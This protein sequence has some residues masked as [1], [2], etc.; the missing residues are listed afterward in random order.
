M[1]FDPEIGSYGAIG[2]ERA[3]LNRT[4]SNNAGISFPAADE[5]KIYDNLQMPGVFINYDGLDEGLSF[6]STNEP[7]IDTKLRMDNNIDLASNY[8][9]G[10]GTNVGL[11]FAG[12]ANATF[13]GNVDCG[14]LV[15]SGYV[16]TGVALLI[17]DPTPGAVPTAS[18]YGTLFIESAS[19]DLKF[20]FNSGTIKTIATDP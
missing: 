13:S 9:S 20:R 12:G 6:N 8:I 10:N 7:V 14:R 1:E 5:I 17:K 18:G 19:G 3:F 4:A 11:S 15:G 16:Q 2:I